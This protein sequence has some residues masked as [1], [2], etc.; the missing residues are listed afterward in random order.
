MQS[1]GFTCG[2]VVGIVDHCASVVIKHVD[3]YVIWKLRFSNLGAHFQVQ[4]WSNVYPG[5]RRNIFYV[6]KEVI[7]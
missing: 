1:S 7:F 2:V 6:K 4:M 3:A 5:R